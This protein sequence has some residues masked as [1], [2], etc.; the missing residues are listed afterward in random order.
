MQRNLAETVLGFV[1]LIVAGVFLYFFISTAHIQSEH[2]YSLNARFGNIGG[3]QVGS[4]VR[5]SGIAVGSVSDRIIDEQTY[6]AVVSL[7]I[8]SHVKIPDDSVVG[9]GSGGFI[10]TPHIVIEPG[11]SAKFLGDGSEFRNSSDF[12]ALEEQIGEVI[13]LATGGKTSN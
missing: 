10:G 5:I 7:S 12:K 3:L 1:V 6:E 11:K 4:D 8:L 2:G 13:F 9:I